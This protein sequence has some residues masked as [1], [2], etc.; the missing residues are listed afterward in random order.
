MRLIKCHIENFG[1]LHNQDFEFCDGLNVICE[2]NGWGKSTLAAFL[3]I[4]LYG[5]ENEKKRDALEKERFRYAPWQ[6]GTFGGSLTFE[7]NGK[8][9][10]LSKRFGKKDREDEA[11]LR[12]EATNL[13]SED[14]STTP[15]EE[16]F[17]L[18]SESFM[19]T[20]FISQS[21][22]AFDVNAGI[23]AK[24]GNLTECA[25]DMNQYDHVNGRLSDLLNQWTPTRKTGLLYKR[26]GELEKYKEELQQQ[27][28]ILNSVERIQQ[29]REALE[30][31]SCALVEEIKKL[32]E[33]QKRLSKLQDGK[34]IQER[35][36]EMQNQCEQ[37]KEGYEEARCFFPKEIPEDEEL[38]HYL[39]QGNQLPVLSRSL[40]IYRMSEEDNVQL[41]GLEQI[42]S[43]GVPEERELNHWEE[44]LQ[45]IHDLEVEQVACR[46]SDGEE[47][48]WN[49]LAGR[50]ENGVP[51]EGEIQELRQKWIKRNACKN[52]LTG[53]KATLET[54]RRIEE[55]ARTQSQ[56]KDSVSGKNRILM[57]IGI[58]FLGA[59][60]LSLGKQSIF[61]SAALFLAGVLAFILGF[62][63][64]NVKK[65]KKGEIFSDE[66]N[67]GSPELKRLE[68]EI[69]SDTL[70]V[71]QI[72]NELQRFGKKYGFATEMQQLG[73]VL[74]TLQLDVRRFQILSDK[75]EQSKGQMQGNQMEQ[76]SQ[77]LHDFLFSYYGSLE[78]HQYAKTLKRLRRD[79]LTYEELNRKRKEYEKYKKQFDE[80]LEEC[81]NFL[82]EYGF[83]ENQSGY[84]EEEI[85][86][87]RMVQILQAVKEHYQIFVRCKQEWE[88]SLKRTNE[89]RRENEELLETMVSLQ[90]EE[91]E[92]VSSME[93]LAV[94]L[95]QLEEQAKQKR[96]GIESY[97][98][99]LYD[100]NTRLDQLGELENQML[101]LQD[102]YDR[103][104]QKYKHIQQTQHYLQKAK[105]ALTEK[106]MEPLLCA[107]SRYYELLTGE[108]TGEYHLDANVTLSVDGAGM[109]RDIRSLSKGYQDLTG[110]CMRMALIDTMYEGEQPFIIMD[111]PFVNLDTGKT[112]CGMNFL[113]Q[114]A[115]KYQIIYF[116]CHDSRA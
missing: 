97:D 77:G 17:S 39:E 70:E 90:A 106:Y 36:K 61:L 32:K 37:Q 89:F 84:E 4:M 5:P 44:Q 43:I 73:N 12:E 103:L 105:E 3:R 57:L 114:V 64:S 78:G 1:K 45:Q 79:A 60:V 31:Q 29:E 35:Y 58:L 8:N 2:E 69:L 111:D 113:R 82:T 62:L 27:E 87:K 74:E 81:N 56:E 9:Y 75:R 110:V 83:Q 33:K 48:E 26:K 72:E 11:Q 95:E 16:L 15:G 14:F 23:H 115:Q 28:V 99:Q 55:Q 47:A 30:K 107:F 91:T 100:Y 67:M 102:E 65:N 112:V 34:S 88:V 50:F 38:S 13:V 10:V 51:Q 6:G 7:A 96:Q 85:Q 24:L 52:G 21:D 104:L 49:I 63:L 86:G 98:R 94:Q 19:R 41:Q 93:E 92:D 116:T 59:F 53:K 40:S 68:E 20:V 108:A 22:C 76:I 18:D 80:I 66:E 25:D 42:F 54:L 101:V 46:L 71:E 109:Q